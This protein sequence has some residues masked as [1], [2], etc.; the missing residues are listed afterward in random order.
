MRHLVF[1]AACAALLASAG[2]SAQSPDAAA[3]VAEAT[4]TMGVTGLK[5]VTFAGNAATGNFGQSRT[6]SFGL[7]ST[8][9]P[10]YIRTIDFARPASLATGTS[11]LQHI[12]PAETAWAQQLQ[13]WSTPWGFLIGAVSHRPTVQVRTVDDV[14]YR[15][16]SW[17]PDQKA[18]SGA[19]YRLEGFVSDRN[20]ID[21]IDTWVEH[22]IMGDLHIETRF[23]NYQSVDGLMVPAQTRQR[24]GGMETFVLNITNIRINPD[25]L[26]ELMTPP[27]AAPR[28]AAPATV[29][30]SEKLADGVYRITGGYVSLAVEFKDYVVVVEAG[31]NEARGLAV[32][33]ETR[34]LFPQKRVKY[35]VN[36]HAHFDHAGGLPPFVADG[37]TI[38]ADDNNKYFLLPA[39]GSPRTLVGD[40]LAKSKK[41]PVIDGVEKKLVLR[42]AT[43]TL[44]LHHVEQ[45]EHSDGMLIA[46][47][48]KERIL[49]TA[50]FPLPVA[51]QP[52]NP[53]TATLIENIT[54]LG[55]DFDRYVTVHAPSPDRPLTR[56]DLMGVVQT[57][58]TQR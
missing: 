35:V 38:V 7:R 8:P 32:L 16:V 52:V 50:D 29:V 40:A 26:D 25:N 53:S 1:A 31:Q 58:G 9:I 10:D 57:G 33:Q 21:Q 23:T 27:P 14:R 6:I 45:L 28:P 39:L 49:F 56:A 44:E 34:R 30:A 51:G 20:V 2:G 24:Q 19:A 41:K 47:L 22:P 4:R 11:Y 43:R 54:R 36:T 48:P 13:I 18:P 17:T 12:T 37:I 5:S 42:D 3:T 46:Y 55:L 15:V